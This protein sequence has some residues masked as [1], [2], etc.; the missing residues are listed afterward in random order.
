M[1]QQQQ[2]QRAWSKAPNAGR[3]N[4]ARAVTTA[5]TETACML[6]QSTCHTAVA[7]GII[8]DWKLQPLTAAA[9]LLLLLLL[10]QSTL[11]Q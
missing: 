4:C 1:Q 6:C 8:L 5:A 9:V 7:H 11:T 2:Q 10:Q 3:C